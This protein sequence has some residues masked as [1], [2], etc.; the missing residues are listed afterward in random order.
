M[1]VTSRMS[2]ML[3]GECRLRGTTTKCVSSNLRQRR[4]QLTL[5]EGLTVYR[6]QEFTADMTCVQ[7]CIVYLCGIMHVCTYIC[8]D[9]CVDYLFAICILYVSGRVSMIWPD[10]IADAVVTDAIRLVNSLSM[11]CVAVRAP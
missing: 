4:F 8:A 1:C 11:S 3:L 6:D 7:C 2:R 5:K 9:S 10:W